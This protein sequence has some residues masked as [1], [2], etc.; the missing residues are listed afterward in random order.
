MDAL[1]VELLV[2]PPRARRKALAAFDRALE[3]KGLKRLPLVKD[4]LAD[5]G[6]M[7][8]RAWT[9]VPL[10]LLHKRVGGARGPSGDSLRPGGLLPRS[11]TQFPSEWE[12]LTMEALT[13]RRLE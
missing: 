9:D 12:G 4:I 8:R 11:P 7:G 13:G 1:Q 6:S 2:A 3:A 10:P 5:L